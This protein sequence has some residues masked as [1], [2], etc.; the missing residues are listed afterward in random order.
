MGYLV[1]KFDSF[2]NIWL[3]SELYFQRCRAIIHFITCSVGGGLQN[4][5]TATL[6]RGKIPSPNECP[7]YDAK[8]SD[9][10]V[11]VMLEL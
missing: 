1:P 10:K 8:Q 6:Q 7:V 11:P 3:L 5:P 2:L 9:G 4:T